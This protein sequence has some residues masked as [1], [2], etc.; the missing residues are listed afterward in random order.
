MYPTV[1]YRIDSPATTPTCI[2]VDHHETSTST[3]QPYHILVTTNNRNDAAT[4]DTRAIRRELNQ[5]KHDMKELKRQQTSPT[6][7]MVKQDYSNDVSSTSTSFSSN[8]QNKLSSQNPF[9]CCN[10]YHHI[11]EEQTY[12]ERPMLRPKTGTTVYQD[13]YK[14]VSSS[15]SPIGYVCYPVYSERPATLKE[16]QKRIPS[17]S[18][19]IQNRPRWIPT[20]AKSNYSNRRWN[21][22]VHH[23]EP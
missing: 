20:S 11:V 21:L 14:P 6:F 19:A 1:I 15:P 18:P 22:S 4:S 7:L 8:N 5:I 23:P 3:R 9:Y 12:A 17:L 2:Y 16:L 13:S 10:E